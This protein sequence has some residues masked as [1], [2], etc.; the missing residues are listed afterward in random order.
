MEGQ[1]IRLLLISIAQIVAVKQQRKHIP[2]INLVLWD[3]LQ[4]F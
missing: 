3:S 2:L 1:K 4:N